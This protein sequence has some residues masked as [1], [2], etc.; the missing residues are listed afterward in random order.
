MTLLGRPEQL[1]RERFLAALSQGVSEKIQGWWA[2]PLRPLGK[3]PQARGALLFHGGADLPA[4]GIAVRTLQHLPE[5]FLSLVQA[6]PIFQR[7]DQWLE[8]RLGTLVEPSCHD[9]RT[10]FADVL[11]RVLGKDSAVSL[12]D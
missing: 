7:Q 11:T 2:F 4:P 8:H 10:G 12:R 5:Q 6:R 1:H 3:C 9:L